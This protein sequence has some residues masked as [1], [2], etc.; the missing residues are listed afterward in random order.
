M[1]RPLADEREIAPLSMDAFQKRRDPEIVYVYTDERGT[2]LFEVVRKPGKKFSQ[3]KLDGTPRLDG[4]RRVPYRLN[5]V[6]LA[7]Q[8]FLCEGEKDVE[9]LRAV[10]LIAS[11]NPNGANGWKSEFAEYFRGKEIILL[12]DQ[13]ATGYA[14]ADRV[15]RDL[16]PVARSI[17]RIDLLGIEF[18]TGGDITDWLAADHTKAELL[19]LVAEAVPEASAEPERKLGEPDKRWG[20]VTRCF[21]DISPEPIRW[22][23]PGRIPLGKLTLLIGDPG[24]GK[25][26]LTLDIAARLSRGSDFPDGTISEQGMAIFLSAEDDCAD[27]IRPRLDAAGADVSRVYTLEAVRIPLADGTATERG[28]SL[29]ADI[30]A[31][32][33]M[34]REH[35]DVRLIVIDPISA[36]LGGVD[37]H[38]NAEVR[39]LLAPLAALAAQHGVAIVAI[40]H[41]PK[42]PRRAV[43]SAVGSIAFAAA[44]RAVWAVASDPEDPE[45]RLMLPVK[46]NL[47]ANNGGLA[48]G[49]KAPDGAA[50]VVWESGTVSVNA[51]EVLACFEDAEGRGARREAESWLGQ[52]LANGPL[53][54]RKIKSEADAAGL[55]WA[56]VRRAKD[57]LGVMAGK[58]GFDEGWSW[59]LPAPEGAHET[60]KALTSK[61]ERLRRNLS[62][63]EE[64]EV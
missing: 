37:S 17:K 55:A 61:G 53:A 10:G 48:F 2:P 60:P 5:E 39:G 22:L 44:A 57:D 12:P 13:D 8:V 28:F 62:T 1:H 41:L 56:T 27:T 59:R 35:P 34:L 50:L 63:F 6:V 40:T 64:G 33:A 42:T 38:N 23:W 20:A 7:E 54:V 15:L 4:V 31:L 9:T 14:W 46:Q 11:T 51:D 49:I 52:M 25:S 30:A 58:D 47:S 16:K 29:E 21:A 26:L 45:R 36:Y 32:D 24:L 3:R 19:S 18:G 43:Q